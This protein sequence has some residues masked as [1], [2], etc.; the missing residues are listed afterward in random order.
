M[1]KEIIKNIQ[2]SQWL[3]V[4]GIFFPNRIEII[5]LICAVLSLTFC[6]K[7]IFKSK[8]FFVL[9]GA[10]IMEWLIIK[11]NGYNDL[12]FFQ[13]SILLFFFILLYEQFFLFNKNDLIDLFRKYIKV[14]YYIALI[15]I[16]QFF[17][18]FLFKINVLSFLSST[19]NM[20]GHFIRATS[21]LS[22]GGYLGT[23]LI[24]SLIYLFYYG[25]PMCLLKKKKRWI[26][27]LA[28]L[29]SL[30]PFSY[31]VILF[32]I[33]AKLIERFK[34]AKYI[35]GGL[36]LL[37]LFYF[38]GNSLQKKNFDAESS[39]IDGIFMR[40]RDT[41]DIMTNFNNIDNLQTLNTSTAVFYGSLYTALHSPS[42]I[43]GT[44]LGTNKQSHDRLFTV[45][46]DPNSSFYNLN[47]DD[48]YSLF[49]RILSEFGFLGLFLYIIFIG[50]CFNRN[51]YINVS[52]FFIIC[53]MF[54]RGGSYVNYGTIFLHFFYFYT[55]KFKFLKCN[56][57]CKSL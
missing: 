4:L 38:I 11:I 12:K 19:Q 8:L 43:V 25:D 5:F 53:C 23:A 37:F 22:E 29:F 51:N 31:F 21:T 39:G 32:I 18:Y 17:I 10:F 34:N 3:I 55:S 45:N 27:V 1:D 7:I 46:F 56:N 13:Q 44:G 57:I 24:P 9:I 40:V 50:S 16:I 48:G 35:L 2:I 47:A 20:N 52:L 6:N 49:T 41:Y 42:R 33:V 28:S 30:S 54:L 14:S 26:V 36:F 15:G